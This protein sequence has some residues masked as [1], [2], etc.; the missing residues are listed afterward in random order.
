[1]LVPC[2]ELAGQDTAAGRLQGLA[3][4]A[5]LMKIDVATVPR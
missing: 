3:T 2:H 1:M 4:C 5:G